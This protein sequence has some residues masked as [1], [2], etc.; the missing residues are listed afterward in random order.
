MYFGRTMQN[1]I[2]QLLQ[3]HDFIVDFFVVFVFF[4]QGD[5]IETIVSFSNGPWP[6][7]ATLKNRNRNLIYNKQYIPYYTIT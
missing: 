4:N 6:R 1:H 2:L 5:H 7:K 3:Q